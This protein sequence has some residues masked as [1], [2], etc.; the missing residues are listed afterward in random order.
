MRELLY[1]KR[2]VHNLDFSPMKV[3]LCLYYFIGFE[4]ISLS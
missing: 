1:Q 3:I 4:M 2:S